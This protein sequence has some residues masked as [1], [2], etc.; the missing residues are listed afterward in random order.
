M[1]SIS[2]AVSSQCKDISVFLNETIFFRDTSILSK[3]SMNF[4]HTILTVDR[5]KVF[6]FDKTQHEFLFL[7]STVT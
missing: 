4:E 2:G 3:S 1:V 6:W 7:L 5:H